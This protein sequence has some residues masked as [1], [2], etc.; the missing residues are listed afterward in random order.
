[1]TPDQKI[2]HAFRNVDS[3]DWRHLYLFIPDSGHGKFWKAV[4]REVQEAMALK[5]ADR[6]QGESS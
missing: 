3:L 1:M 2:V 5:T 4:F 6:K